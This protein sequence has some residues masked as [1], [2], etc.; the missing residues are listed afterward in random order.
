MEDAW[1]ASAAT[2]GKAY[3]QRKPNKKLQNWQGQKELKASQSNTQL[4]GAL[5]LGPVAKAEGASL[6]SWE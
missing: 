1:N 4:A 2:A 6:R 5:Q 3:E